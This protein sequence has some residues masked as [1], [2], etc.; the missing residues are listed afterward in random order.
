M[1]VF[2]KVTN[3]RKRDPVREYVKEYA[4]KTTAV[5]N[6]SVPAGLS[7]Q[8]ATI[9]RPAPGT[10]PDSLYAFPTAPSA[11]NPYSYTVANANYPFPLTVHRPQFDFVAKQ[12]VKEAHVLQFAVNARTPATGVALSYSA[13]N[14]PAG[15]S[16]APATRTLSW[17]P[18]YGQAGTY[19]MQFIVD[20]GVIP[21]TQNVSVTVT[22]GVAGD[23]NE[24]AA[25]NCVDV[26]AASSIIGR[27]TGQPGFLPTADIDGNG[28]IDIRDVSAIARLLPAGTHC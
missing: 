5:T 26:L 21:E 27:R 15:A 22:P 7:V 12:T 8:E 18:R 17:T 24:D 14:L 28:V 10:P 6:L 16:F 3:T 4:Y 2:V 9:N 20:D 19:T 1:P 13:A 11:A 23:V 25:I